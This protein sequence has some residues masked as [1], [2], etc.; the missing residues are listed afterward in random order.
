[1]LG[2][3]KLG[4]SDLGYNECRPTKSG[5]QAD[6]LLFNSFEVSIALSQHKQ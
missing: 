6:F 3:A 5:P 4:F 2:C 1:M